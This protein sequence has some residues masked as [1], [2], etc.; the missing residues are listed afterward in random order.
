[1]KK[2]LI[3]IGFIF[4][5]TLTCYASKTCCASKTKKAG[6]LPSPPHI[7]CLD[8]Q[9]LA[10]AKKISKTNPTLKLKTA[11]IALRKKADKSLKAGP[12]SVM[13]KKETPPSGDKHDYISFGTYWWPD[14]NKKDGLPYIRRDGHANP[15]FISHSDIRSL[16]SMMNHVETLSLTYY[17]FDKEEYAAHAAELMRVWFLNPKTKM[18]PNLNF[19]QNVPGHGTG[20]RC[21]GIIETRDLPIVIDSIGL[22]QSSKAWTDADQK[23]MVKWFKSYLHWLLTSP[24]G[25]EENATL[26]NHATWYDVQVASMALFVGNEELAAKT[27]K[28]FGEKRIAKQIKPDGT[29]PHELERT[30]SFAYSLMNLHGM[31]KMATIAQKLDVDLWNYQSPDG[32]N[33]RK[34]LDFL[35]PYLD[36]EKEFPYTQ[37]HPRQNLFVHYFLPMLRQANLIYG[38]NSYH[39]LI[40]KYFKNEVDS[41]SILLFHPK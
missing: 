23:G 28:A 34:A 40:E 14:P 3:I 25:K 17:F 36:L 32:S 20:G 16:F 4:T 11:C 37:L 9:A 7:F 2:L 30:K 10:R 12:F 13:N 18:N 27:I 24:L 29:Q 6:P 22:L 15:D 5:L 33:I 41:P 19:G 21:Y 31:F 38:K 26:N 35:A 8:P 1:L 39:P